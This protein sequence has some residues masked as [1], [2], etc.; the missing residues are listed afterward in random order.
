VADLAADNNLGWPLMAD[1][2]AA[3]WCP[4]SSS[5]IASLLLPA[6]EKWKKRGKSQLSKHNDTKVKAKKVSK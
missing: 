6:V 3:V 5:A 2:T 1:S 4:L